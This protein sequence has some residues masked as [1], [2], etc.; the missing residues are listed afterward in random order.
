MSDEMTVEIASDWFKKPGQVLDFVL[1]I[2]DKKVIAY[3]KNAL[4]TLISTGLK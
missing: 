2:P 4:D 1:D 3:S